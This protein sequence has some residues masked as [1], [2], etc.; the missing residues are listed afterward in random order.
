MGGN[1]VRPD[2]AGP[3]WPRLLPFAGA[4]VLAFFVT[5]L[6]TECDP[7]EF[8][9]A[10]G[11]L[12]SSSRW[13]RCSRGTTFRSACARYLRL[14]TCSPPP[15]FAMPRAASP[16]ASGSWRCCPCSG[17]RSTAGARAA[18]GGRRVA[19]YYLLPSL[20]LGGAATYPASGYRTAVLFVAVSAIVGVTVQRLV[21]DGRASALEVERHSRDLHV[22]RISAA[23]SRRPATPA[24]RSARPPV[25]SAA[26]ASHCFS[27]RTGTA[28]SSPRRR[29]GS[30]PRRPPHPSRGSRRPRTPPSPPGRPVFIAQSEIVGAVDHAL[31]GRARQPEGDAVRARRPERRGG[32]RARPR[33]GRAGE[34]GPPADD[35]RAARRRGRHRHRAR[36]V[37]RAAHR[38]RDDRRP[39]RR[40]EPA[41]GGRPARPRARGPG[42]ARVLH[43]DARSRQLQG[44]QRHP[45][46]PERR[47]APPGRHRGLARALGRAT[48]SPATAARSSPCC[49]PTA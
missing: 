20:L 16:P 46:P 42:P 22:W 24:G 3:A 7:A 43:R 35:R 12:G 45:R 18:G 21:A 41:R 26:R 17:S 40:D 1:A 39:H 29:P 11:M 31:L 2:P 28:T 44:L 38:P 37:R 23:S 32:G 13:P 49:S 19:A 48:S 25:T 8:A 10:V 4:A 14:S 34:R 6:T 5:G 47:P 27:S 33:L 9:G 15:S 30:T 36:G